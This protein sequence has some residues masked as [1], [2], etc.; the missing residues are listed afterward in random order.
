MPL[1]RRT[2][3]LPCALLLTFVGATS[4]Q[5]SPGI[6]IDSPANGAYVNDT[7]PTVTYTGATGPT[8]VT[9]N[10]DGSPI[11]T[12]PVAD[13][14]VTPS[15]PIAQAPR[16]QVTLSVDDDGGSG[17]SPD[18]QVYVDQVPDI[19]GTGAGPVDPGDVHFDASTAIPGNDVELYSAGPDGVVGNGDDVLLTT[20]SADGFGWAE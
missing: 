17:R 9:L 19:S 12:V 4:A 11:R 1:P 18:V 16:Q 14:S 10:V 20:G 13:G 15:T 8:T 3:A 7:T 2:L 5:A 6:T